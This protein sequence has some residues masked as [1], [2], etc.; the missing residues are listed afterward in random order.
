MLQ[1]V[2]LNNAYIMVTNQPKHAS[3][4]EA[5]EISHHRQLA[6]RGKQQQGKQGS[7][8]QQPPETIWEEGDTNSPILS[9]IHKRQASKR[10]KIRVRM[11]DGKRALAAPALWHCSNSQRRHAGTA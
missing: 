7:S 10:C 2:Y 9:F 4:E 5:Q 3:K 6:W 1:E 11:M 8:H